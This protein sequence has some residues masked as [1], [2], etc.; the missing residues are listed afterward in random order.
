[1]SPHPKKFKA[2][3]PQVSHIDTD[4]YTDSDIDT[5][6]PPGLPPSDA[7]LMHDTSRDMSMEG[8]KDPQEVIK[9][10]LM[11]CHATAR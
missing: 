5:R 2:R 8:S 7:D 10:P 6:P 11:P 3:P 9:A 4:D 1:M